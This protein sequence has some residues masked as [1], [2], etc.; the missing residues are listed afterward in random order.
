MYHVIETPLYWNPLYKNSYFQNSAQTLTLIIVISL[1]PIW[2]GDFSRVF[3]S[4]WGY[5]TSCCTRCI[6]TVVLP[7]GLKYDVVNS[8]KSRTLSNNIDTCRAVR[9]YVLD[10]ACEGSCTPRMTSHKLRKKEIKMM[11]Q[12]VLPV[13]I[14]TRSWEG[15]WIAKG[16]GQHTQVEGFL[17]VP[18]SG[19]SLEYPER[20]PMTFSSALTDSFVS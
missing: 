18:R 19:Y 15:N 8:Q 20:K 17:G 11:N 2:S 10:N 4:D 14:L 3:S 7:C 6:C 16:A 13:I 9:P 12:I 1:V 5:W